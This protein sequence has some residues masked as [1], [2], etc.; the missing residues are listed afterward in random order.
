MSTV[1]KSIILVAGGTG[2]HIYPAISTLQHLNDHFDVNVITDQRGSK[3]FEGIKHQNSNK[4]NIEIITYKIYSPFNQSFYNTLKLLYLIPSNS[5]KLFY[6]IFRLKPDLVLGFGGYT[7]IIPCLIGKLM[8][9]KL[10]IHEQNSIM[11]RAN[12]L[13]EFF[14]SKSFISFINTYPVSNLEKRIY[15][16]TPIRKEFFQKKRKKKSS[17]KFNILI[18]GGSLGSE[19]LSET[20]ANSLCSIGKKLNKEISVSHQVKKC[21]KNNIKNLYLKNKI[22]A[23]VDHFFNK[24]YDKFFEADLII[25]RAGGSTIAEIIFS[26]KISIIFPLPKSLDNHQNVNSKIISENKIGWVMYE[27][28]FSIK[29]FHKI[30]QNLV[31]SK[32]ITSDLKKNMTHFKRKNDKLLGNKKPN[33]IIF[34][35]LKLISK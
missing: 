27:D 12:R 15:C 8:G 33:E 7:S 22:P 2:G 16:C 18:F 21:Q 24:I 23:S 28:S 34:E 20:I 35:N 25:S 29:K 11:G 26:Q 5:I 32:K 14:S 31:M 6:N 3:Y 17:D 19:T 13:L 10:F 30:I 1:R 9:K 4:K